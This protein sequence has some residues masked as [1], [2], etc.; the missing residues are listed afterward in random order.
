MRGKKLKTERG[1]WFLVEKG[2]HSKR[3]QTQR[4]YFAAAKKLAEKISQRMAAEAL[5]CEQILEEIDREIQGPKDRVDLRCP[6]CGL[7][8]PASPIDD[9]HDEDHVRCPGCRGLVRI[10]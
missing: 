3:P 8:W 1:Y 2:L 4:K 6:S 7:E 9:A 5:E 10:P